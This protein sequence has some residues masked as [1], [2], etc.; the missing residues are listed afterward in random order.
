MIQYDRREVEALKRTRL[1]G[2]KMVKKSTSRGR[3]SCG[4]TR[5]FD[6]SGQ[7]TGRKK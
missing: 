2:D 3:G 1:G 5:K 4:G 7:G 6:G